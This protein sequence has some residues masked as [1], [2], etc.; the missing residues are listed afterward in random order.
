M[1]ETEKKRESNRKAVAAYQK[2]QDN[3]MIRP[4]KEHGAKIRAAAAK[5]GLS[6]QKYILQVLDEKLAAEE[7]SGEEKNVPKG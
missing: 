2:R 3:I 1:S 4:S 6:V 7:Q 5:A